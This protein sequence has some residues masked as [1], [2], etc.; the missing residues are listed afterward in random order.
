LALISAAIENSSRATDRLQTGYEVFMSFFDDA[1]VF[2][3]A[4]NKPIASMQAAA[5]KS[6]SN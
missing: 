1:L 2:V 6:S 4:S 3:A 5:T